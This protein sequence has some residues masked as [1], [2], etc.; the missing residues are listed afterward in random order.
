MRND[1]T[2]QA[3]ALPLWATPLVTIMLWAAVVVL[4]LAGVVM[5]TIHGD[6]GVLLIVAALV[7]AAPAAASSRHRSYL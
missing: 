4:T 1:Y 6:T 5:L 2:Q 7:V 3:S